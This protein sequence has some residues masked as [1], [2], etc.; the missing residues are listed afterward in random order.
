MLDVR[1]DT[2]RNRIDITHTGKTSEDE[3]SKRRVK[4]SVE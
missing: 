4:A 1:T 2:T 3:A